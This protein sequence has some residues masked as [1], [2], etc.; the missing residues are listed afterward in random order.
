MAFQKLSYLDYNVGHW[1]MALNALRRNISRITASSSAGI[2]T[3]WRHKMRIVVVTNTDNKRNELRTT[4]FN[5]CKCCTCRICCCCRCVPNFI[6]VC[7][8]SLGRND[9]PQ[10]KSIIL[11]N[12][13]PFGDLWWVV[14][15]INH[16]LCCLIFNQYLAVY[17]YVA[18]CWMPMYPS[19]CLTTLPLFKVLPTPLSLSY[20]LPHLNFDFLL[21]QSVYRFIFCSYLSVCLS[22]PLSVYLCVSLSAC[23]F[24]CIYISISLRTLSFCLSFCLPLSP[25]HRLIPYYSIIIHT[26]LY[27]GGTILVNAV[28]SQT[29]WRHLLATRPRRHGDHYATVASST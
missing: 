2:K 25:K 15:L 21:C 13:M 9:T 19:V 26:S 20:S 23:L 14:W 3:S 5:I 28:S 16:L 10:C 7:N 12:V 17:L 24:V 29:P 11:I 8:T 1:I 22:I 4:G 6:V 18:F 27:Y